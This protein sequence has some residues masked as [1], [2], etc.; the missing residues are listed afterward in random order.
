VAADNPYAVVTGADGSFTLTQVPAGTY[1]IEI[2]HLEL[3]TKT[4]DV[5]VEAGGTT[6][7]DAE[8]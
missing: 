5:T 3:G 4:F 2:W 8:F 6:T 1:R 7:Q